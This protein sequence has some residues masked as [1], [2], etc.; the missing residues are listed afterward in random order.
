M[1]N[2]VTFSENINCTLVNFN[3]TVNSRFAP[4][5]PLTIKLNSFQKTVNGILVLN[6]VAVD[7]V[8][9][10]NSGLFI[11]YTVNNNTTSSSN[12]TNQGNT[13][14]NPL[15]INVSSIKGLPADKPFTIT[16]IIV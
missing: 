1:S 10:P 2:Q 6:A 16:A 9:L 15:T 13:S 11:A 8:T 14:S 5:A 12:T 3:V 7:K 4:T